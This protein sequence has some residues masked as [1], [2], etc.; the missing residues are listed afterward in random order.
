MLFNN[1]KVQLFTALTYI[2]SWTLAI[3]FFSFGGSVNSRGYFILGI[4]YMFMPAIMAFLVQK[5]ISKEP[6]KLPLG[7]SFKVNAWFFI[8]WIIPLLLVF[9]TLLISLLIPGVTYSPGMEGMF[10]RLSGLM[11]ADEI[12]KLK[13]SYALAPVHPVW[14]GVI[15]GL[16]AG[17]SINA[18]AGFGE[19]LGW[20]GFLYNELKSLGFWKMSLITGLIWGI[21]HAPLVIKGH[22]YYQHPIVGVLMMAAWCIL[23]APLFNYVRIKS[24]SV[25]ATSI[26]HGTLNATYGLALILIKGGND[27]TVGITGLAGFAA[28]IIVTAVIYYFDVYE[29]ANPVMEKLF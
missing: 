25:I 23:L 4:D 2:F 10:E 19:E 27:L 9:L 24:G 14:I 8:G 20:R 15:Q 26:M 3:L 21:W 18:I 12:E 6:L 29:S 13:S 1:K 5:I 28:I 11:K 16:L 17:A 7:I 22:N